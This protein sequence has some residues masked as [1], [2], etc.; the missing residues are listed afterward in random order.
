MLNGLS[1]SN[2]MVPCVF[3]T[4]SPLTTNVIFASMRFLQLNHCLYIQCDQK[5]MEFRTWS[6]FVSGCPCYGWIYFDQCDKVTS[7]NP[8]VRWEARNSCEYF[9]FTTF[10]FIFIGP[11]FRSRHECLLRDRVGDHQGQL[12]LPSEEEGWVSYRAVFRSLQ[13]S[14]PCIIW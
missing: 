10:S 4:F 1:L 14:T 12:L 8:T 7:K 5:G 9:G 3:S 13:T 11:I 2:C 6:G